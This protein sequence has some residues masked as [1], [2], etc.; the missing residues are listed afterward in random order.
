MRT[1][2][3]GAWA[4]L[5]GVALMMLGNGLQVSLLGIRASA[6]GFSTITTGL[7]MTGYFVG[8]LAGSTLT[9]V[10]VRQ[11]GHVRVFAALASLAS[12]SVLIHA[13]FLHPG[14]WITMRFFTGLSYAGLY[15]VTESWLNDQ[16]TNETRGRLLSIYMVM[17]LGGMS[18][19]QWLLNLASPDSFELF[20]VASALVSVAL[21]PVV[22]SASRTPAFETPQSMGLLTLYRV[23]PLGVLAAFGTG[24]AHS[25]LF[26][27]GAVY[28][29]LSGLSVSQTA[30]FMGIA[31]LGGMLA[32]W[33]VG[34]LS[35]RFDRRLVITT[36]T[37]LAGA[38]A[39][40]GIGLT[41]AAPEV[42]MIMIALV[43][44]LSMPLY[45]LA[46]A[47]TNDHLQQPQMVAASSTLVLVGGLGAIFGPLLASAL[48]SRLG[49]DGFLWW[50]GG[51]HLT[52]GVFAVYRMTRRA[53]PPMAS[54]GSA[55]YIA[56]GA[57]PLATALSADDTDESAAQGAEHTSGVRT[58]TAP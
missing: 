14:V 57:G 36:V 39:L 1:A 6:E 22:L 49:A 42:M 8:F 3:F 38:A 16:A 44:A 5:L 43:G 47:H 19:G 54:Q 35:D 31:I 37:L 10:A 56:P 13:V 41:P 27:M 46:I 29:V 48:M 20:I 11:V 9:P 18:A 30:S 40:A 51:V 24:S 17:C 4:L 21:I 28:A 7:V 25:A 32:Q 55:A 15:V 2:I 45:S 34:W 58:D 33:P 53:A 23:S 12:V 52:I 26:G 50:I